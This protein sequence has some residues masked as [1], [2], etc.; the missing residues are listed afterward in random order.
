MYVVYGPEL[1]K[2]LCTQNHNTVLSLSKALQALLPKQSN[3]KFYDDMSIY[4]LHKGIPTSLFKT[5]SEKPEVIL[6]FIK[7]MNE[8]FPSY[9]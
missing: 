9:T 2:K 1:E 8:T 3:T 5:M 7:E 6:K 4:I